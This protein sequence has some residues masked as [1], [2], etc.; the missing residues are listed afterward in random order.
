MASDL[1]NP[2]VFFDISIAGEEAGRIVMT[3]FADVVPRTAENFRCLCTG[4]AGV[5]RGGKPLHYKGSLFHRVIPQF[6]CQGG[7]FENA[8]GTGGQSIYGDTFADENF[9]LKHT[10]GGLLSMANAGPGTNGSQF[11]ITTAP[12][13]WLDG[14]HVVFGKVTEGL[15]VVKRMESL[16]SKS[17]RT[18]QKIYIADCGELPSKR[19]IMAKILREREEAAA[20]KQDPSFVDPDEEARA[21]LRALTAGGAKPALPFK[22]A[23]D[24]LRELEERERQE[25]LARQAAA[26]G[27][28]ALAVAAASDEDGEERRQ[29]G[30]AAAGGGEQK[31]G[32]GE[33]GG[34]AY[35]VDPTAGMNARQKKLWELQQRM[36]AARKANEH[37]VV[38]EK[39]K[40][41]AAKAAESGPEGGGGA[42]GNKRKWF[43]D[44]QKKK[45]EELARLGL[46]PDKAYLLETAETAEALAKKKEKKPAPEGWEQFNQASLAA[47]YER[48]TEKIKP[49]RAE[50]EA[51][52]ASDPEF[53]RA[54]DSLLY[55]QGKPSEAAVDR[56]VA[57]L[58][59]RRN[60][61]FSR[62]RAH[63]EDKDIDY[64]NDRNAHFNRK[65]ERIFGEH[66]A[67]IKANLERGTALPDH[68]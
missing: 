19:Q 4:E 13:P 47:A 12:C 49:D 24:E 56:M 30:A 1:D 29:D 5:A 2:R 44:K 26:G 57:E 7:D 22:T 55:G 48:R 54:A 62:R 37:A 35:S 63:R 34:A 68:R 61:S 11:F 16:G 42:G 10:D 36:K 64:I 38:A 59:D 45:E 15:P 6:M 8:D 66:T 40:A 18:A 60:K 14:K 31:G 32:D 27:A 39:K 3:L 17:G 58:N 33:E 52:K 53:Y 46:A 20:M 28:P 25:E 41:A 9:D 43:E 51:A 50:Y 23:Q 21:R 67:E 65:I